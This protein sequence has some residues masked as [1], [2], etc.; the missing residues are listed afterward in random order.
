[1]VCLSAE[2]STQGHL[3]DNELNASVLDPQCIGL[4][5]DDIDYTACLFRGVIICFLEDILGMKMRE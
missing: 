1:M 4:V 5:T 2:M 3:G